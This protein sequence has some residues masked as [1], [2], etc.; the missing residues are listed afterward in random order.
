MER[1]WAT[2]DEEFCTVNWRFRPLVMSQPV[3]CRAPGFHFFDDRIR[4][5]WAEIVNG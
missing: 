3:D 2:Q 1:L 5:F 4:L